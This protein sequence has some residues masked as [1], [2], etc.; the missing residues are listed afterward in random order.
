MTATAGLGFKLDHLDEAL[1]CEAD[2]LWFEVDAEHYMVDGG[3]RLAALDA[4][5]ARRPVS[6]HGV[7]LLLSAEGPDL[8]HL[9]RFRRLIDRSW[10]CGRRS[11]HEDHYG[12]AAFQG[13]VADLLSRR[14]ETGD[15]RLAQAVA[16]HC[17]TAAKAVHD[18][19]VAN[20]SLAPALGQEAFVACAGFHAH[21]VR[22]Q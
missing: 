16:V 8:D 3:A 11:M 17:S 13:A 22:G 15:P 2:G 18:A 4:L 9:R 7:G 1:A 6:L 21:A 20:H 10:P 5:R 12:R 14:R 19:L